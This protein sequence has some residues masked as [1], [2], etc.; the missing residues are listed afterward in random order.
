MQSE[1]SRFFHAAV[2]TQVDT[3]YAW[4]G[5][6]EKEVDCSGLVIQALRNIPGFSSIPDKSADEILHEYCRVEDANNGF[7]DIRL[8]FLTTGKSGKATH[9]VVF[10]PGSDAYVHATES[11]GLVTVDVAPGYY[12]ITRQLDWNKL[13][14]YY[15]LRSHK[16]S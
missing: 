10:L 5:Q 2:I 14:Q 3:P 11:R 9:V 8:G 15:S 6:N 13:M 12:S 1:S 16:P 7:K 4:G